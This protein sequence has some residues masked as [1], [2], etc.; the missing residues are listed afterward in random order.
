MSLY[1]RVNMELELR[2]SHHRDLL[3]SSP[4]Q[5]NRVAASVIQDLFGPEYDVM[6]IT[7]AELFYYFFMAK[8]NTLGPVWKFP[9]E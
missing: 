9:W 5:A 4:S 2:V 7:L 3:Q 8:A 6:K 1:P